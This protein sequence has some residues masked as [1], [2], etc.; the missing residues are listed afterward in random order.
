VLALT[1]TLLVAAGR[2]RRRPSG[3]LNHLIRLGAMMPLLPLGA[4]MLIRLPRN[5]I[6]WILCGASLGIA[7][8][9]AAQEYAVYSHFVSGLPAERWVGWFGSGP[10]GQRL[11][12]TVA[13]L[14]FPTGRLPSR[15]WRPVLWLGIAGPTL[16]WL[17]AFLG[18]GEDLRFMSNPLSNTHVQQS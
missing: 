7:L 5:A 3:T 8:A 11:R 2:A 14:L 4:L 13:L 12:S 18:P 16:V 10:A 15:R 17:S 1:L 9:V 6:G